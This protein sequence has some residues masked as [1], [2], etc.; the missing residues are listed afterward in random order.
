M[1]VVLMVA[2]MVDMLVVLMVA[3]LAEK[4][5]GMMVEKL[6]LQGTKS[7]CMNKSF[8]RHYTD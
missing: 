1:M 3:M 7:L 4:M 2:V 8:Q 6:D 5:V